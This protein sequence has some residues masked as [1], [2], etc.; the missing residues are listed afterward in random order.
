M[1]SS[2]STSCGPGMASARA[3]VAWCRPVFSLG[4]VSPWANMA[5]HLKESLV[6]GRTPG[7]ALTLLSLRVNL[8]DTWSYWAAGRG[9][10]HP[11]ALHGEQ[12][13]PGAGHP[14]AGDQRQEV[15]GDGDLRGWEGSTRKSPVC[16]GRRSPWT[17]ICV[18]CAY[19]CWPGPA[20]W[21]NPASL[22]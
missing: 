5:G 20:P 21:R 8:V 6:Q 12:V 2:S 13:D 10:A 1:R 4:G 17:D 3:R 16:A 7:A 9:G 14:H 18:R 15:E 19:T 11:G 22:R